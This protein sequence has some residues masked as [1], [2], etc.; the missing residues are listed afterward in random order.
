[1]KYVREDRAIKK[2]GKKIREIRIQQKISQ[3]QLAFEANI[4]TMQV[5]RIERGEVNTSISSIIRIAKVLD[6]KVKDLFD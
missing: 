2:L 5:S 1:M 4:P 3:A 6:V